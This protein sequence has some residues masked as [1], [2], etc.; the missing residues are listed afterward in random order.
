[1]TLNMAVYAENKAKGNLTLQN[2][3]PKQFQIIAKKFDPDT[4]KP[5]R[6][7]IMNIERS[8]AEQALR[9]FE[10]ALANVTKSIENV[11]QLLAD[12]DAI[13]VQE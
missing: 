5:L 8:G 6:S 3:G 9:G 10:E 2:V 7:D 11:K 4:G 13:D 12:M 1:M